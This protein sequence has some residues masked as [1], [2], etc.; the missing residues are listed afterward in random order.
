MIFGAG[1]TARGLLGGAGRAA[2][3]GMRRNPILAGAVLGATYGSFSN[4][5]S[6]LGGATM[7]AGLA[8]GGRYGYRA[9]NR[10]LTSYLRGGSF[11]SAFG[12]SI[13][14]MAR[15]D[16]GRGRMVVNSGYNKI[17]GLWR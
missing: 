6:M 14:R 10:G 5:T 16:F 12:T 17:R 15:S 1:L 11:R 9:L 7:G 4:N 13:S 8:T 3:A 2:W